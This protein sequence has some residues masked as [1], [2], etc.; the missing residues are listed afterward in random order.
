MSGGDGLRLRVRSVV[1]VWVSELTGVA[2]GVAHVG[3]A[4]GR[5]RT[6]GVVSKLV[7][8]VF[9]MFDDV[10]RG[11]CGCVMCVCVDRGT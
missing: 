11:F 6:D 3:S 1:V 9:E 10:V 4:I 5:V 2:S 8:C 7:V